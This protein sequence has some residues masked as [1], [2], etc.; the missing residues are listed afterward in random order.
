V[1]TGEL[2]CIF[3]GVPAVLTWRQQERLDR[4]LDW[5]E[6]QSLGVVQL[7][8]PEYC[9][10]PWPQL[11]QYLARADGVVILGFK[12]L[13]ARRAIWRPGTSEESDVAG[14]WT[15]PWLHLEAGMAI[16]MRMPLLVAAEEDVNEG[17]FS[18]EVWGD[19]LHGAAIDDPGGAAWLELVRNHSATR[20]Q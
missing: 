6:R 4:W 17:V 3:M 9:A 18:R 10:E 8:R 15:S 13:D 2:P 19:Y 16:A 5:I 12:Q 1:N 20:S 11:R 14:W 7:E